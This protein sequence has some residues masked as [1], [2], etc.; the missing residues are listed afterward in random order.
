MIMDKEEKIEETKVCKYC[1]S[2]IPKK[3]KICPVCKKKQKGKGRIIVIAA[4]V[5]LVII[6]AISGGN[7]EE[8]KINNNA[9]VPAASSAESSNENNE[10][11]NV[12]L[13]GGSFEV[14]GLKVTVNDAT[15]DYQL[16]DNPYGMYDL[17]SGLMYVAVSFTFENTG[18]SDKYVSIYD[19][20]CYADD[21]L[22]E[23]Q[24]VS[25]GGDFMNANLSSGRNISF[26][27]FYAVSS[28][29]EEIE[30]EYTANILTDEKVV[31]KVL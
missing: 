4:V 5:L 3:A 11:D 28:D 15:V 19:F 26:T 18:D 14:K 8:T 2:E 16:K 6:I 25:D 17:D 13:P 20:D 7:K 21:V 22:C 24:Y 9:T 30:L 10:K 1:Q 31:I 29:A 12:V 27:T 23:Q